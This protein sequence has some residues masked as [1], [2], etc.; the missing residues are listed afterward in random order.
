MKKQLRAQKLLQ[1]IMRITLLQT[2]LI[3]LTLTL[4]Y[5]HDA[6]TQDLLDRAVSIKSNNA[7]L[8]KVLSKIE[9]EVDVKFVYS[10]T[11]IQPNRR[12]S[13]KADQ[14]KLSE[15]LAMVLEPLDISYRVIGG[16][17]TLTRY[18]TGASSVLSELEV[19]VVTEQAVT[20]IVTDEG[21][22]ALPGVSILVKGT[23]RGTTTNVEGSYSVVV[24]DNNA[25][26]VFSYVGYQSQEV[27]IEN[28]TRLDVSLKIDNKSL[29]E[30]VVVG[31]GTQRRADI[32][33]S[34]ASVNAQD[35]K[36]I[37]SPSLD[38][39]MTGRMPGVYVAQTTGTPGGG[40]TVRVRGSGSI[41]AGNEPLY[42]IDGFP[43]TANYNQTSNPLNSINPNDIESIEVLKDA[44]ATAIYGSRGSNGVV[45]VTTKAG[46]SGKMTVDIDSYVGV[47]NVV[48]TI[49]LM[50]ASEFAQ[51]I[52]DSRNNAYADTGGD[53]NAPNDKRGTIYKIL[54]ELQNPE[55][56]G[57]GTDWQKE[58]YRPAAMRNLQLRV[59][60]GNDRV[61]FMVSGGYLKQEG[62]II[63][64]DFERY[65]FRVNL[66][67]QASKR[68]KIGVNL[69]PAYT[70]ANPTEAEGHWASGGIVLSALSIAPHVPVYDADGNYTTALGLGN[71][72]SS[73][74]NPV[75]LA[76]ERTYTN[77]EIRLLATSFADY[78]IINGLNY[79]LLL[80]TDLQSSNLRTFNPSIVG[81]DG[82]PPPVIPR[83]TNNTQQSYN[84]LVE[85][86]LT[87][88][89][90]FNKHHI[91]ALAGFTSQKVRSD[92]SGISSTNFPNDLVQTLNAG[93]VI[94]ASTSATEWSLL[95]YLS[96]INYSY[97]DRYLL[98]ATI[99]RDG[100][101]RFGNNKKWGVFPSISAGWR[102]SEEDFMKNIKI[103][104]D[105]KVR[106]S[107]GVTGNNFIGNYDHVG[108]LTKQNY[109]FGQG[110]GTV[111]NGLGPDR[112]SNA[113]LSWE[114]NQQLD[115]GLELGLLKNRIY[116]IADYYRKITSDLLLNVPTPSLT[117][118][119]SAR[120]NIGKVEN[121]GFE[122]GL[123]TRNLVN[124]F[125]WNSDFNI[126]FNRNK[127][128]LLGPSGEPIFGSYQLSNSHVTQIG[129]PLGSFYGYQVIGI[130]QTP[131]EVN[132]NASFA[133]SKPGHYRFAD[134]DG[135]GKLS[136][137]D[138]T[139][140]GNAQPDFIF[141]FTNSISYKGFDMSVLIQGVQGNEILNLGRRFYANY[142][143]TA[144][145]L[146][147]VLNSWK[148]PQEPGDGKTPRVNRDLSRYSS[149][150][151]SA[152]ITSGQVEEASFVRIRNIS[153]GYSAPKAWASKLRLQTLRLYVNVQ[154]PV[155]WTKYT[156]Y[157]PEVSVAGANPLAPGVDYGG[158]PIARVLTGGL[159]LSF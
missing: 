2:V 85:H 81:I 28:R 26:L 91:N 15:V 87:Y 74:E 122:L 117:G 8:R 92:N 53:I 73:I 154:N 116:L 19:E 63:N 123:N 62:V 142:A 61:R 112:I 30:V 41:G 24:P 146:R 18:E 128:L 32:T 51:Y 89:K 111:V 110:G 67:A 27:A 7:E 119:T 59:A 34:L 121:K 40:L 156:G 48:K 104:S 71:G 37:P 132:D 31:Y 65:S 88:G 97:N 72:F 4:V 105:L 115:V 60:G 70:V 11:V 96:R 140:L 13:V 118:Y 137:D 75:K 6:H 143:G 57:E 82:V 20:G 69:T 103:V 35:I 90:T 155:T 33:G 124:E 138:R 25:V 83:G 98:T 159:N 14:R 29:D 158:Y 157:N 3:C 23:V 54:P 45:I 55:S 107:Y 42:V 125:K 127:V 150:N 86:T 106:A 36:D 152:N 100:S 80:G 130:F 56:L 39:T 149:S 102:I 38:A 108:L 43:V 101:S 153:V 84:W 113:N 44:S 131:E 66:D 141:G 95:S 1:R 21:G 147:E 93:I 94:G 126:S 50:N 144:N 139:I 58:I 78:Q 129:K 16:Q 47:Q 134:I 68:L 148:S 99:R 9:S 133:D 120:Q 17:I 12:V 5:A 135:D 10:S 22:G 46:K 64:S 151:T 136:V 145:S 76:K 114:R 49:D 79:K 77:N 52:K 109:V